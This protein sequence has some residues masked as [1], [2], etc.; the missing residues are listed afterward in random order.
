MGLGLVRGVRMDKTKNPYWRQKLEHIGFVKKSTV[1]P[2]SNHYSE[3]CRPYATSYIFR[4][5]SSVSKI[6]GLK[7]LQGD[8]ILL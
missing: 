8:A 5:H 6:P 7:W 2:P 1:T 3:M 4:V